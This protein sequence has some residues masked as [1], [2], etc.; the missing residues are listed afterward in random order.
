MSAAKKFTSALL[1]TVV[2]FAM[3][4]FFSSPARYAHCILEGISLWAA[5]VLP[6]TFPLLFLTALMTGL[7]PF[8]KISQKLSPIAGKLFRVS[9]AGGGAAVLSA[10]SGYPVGA[11]LV[12]DARENGRVSQE[13]TFR[14]S[15][16]C[17][18]SGPMFLVGTVGCLMYGSA[19][20]GWIALCAHLLSVWFVF[21]LLRF[22]AKPVRTA[23][24]TPTKSP[25][26]LYEVLY[27]SILSVLCVGGLIALFYCFSQMLSD[28]GLFT[29]ARG[30]PYAEGVLRG[31]LEMTTGCSL[32]S[33]SRTPLS[34]ALS[35][36]LVTLGGV[37]I[38]CQQISYLSRAGVK[39][40]P[41]LTIKFVQAVL[42]FALCYALALLC[43]I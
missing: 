9:G 7:T 8:I 43:G 19:K 18:T 39:T 29:F 41:F 12:F 34:L 5:T 4:V 10:L 23:P 3:A 36:A 17:S 33:A 38:L 42:A 40:L 37:C 35:C 25:I 13:E 26:S 31:L 16:L 2:L 27:H 30:I 14:L 21:F 11:K 28:I 20:A 15:C 22:R 24:P 32:L 6:A 1:F